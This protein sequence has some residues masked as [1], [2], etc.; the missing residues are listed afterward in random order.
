MCHLECYCQD[1]AEFGQGGMFM[2][3]ALTFMQ[4]F[5]VPKVSVKSLLCAANLEDCMGTG[6]L[7]WYT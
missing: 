5:C 7:S 6:L 1:G 3:N 4:L 2:A